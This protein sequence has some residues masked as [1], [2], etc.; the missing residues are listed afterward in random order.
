MT[1]GKVY[2]GGVFKCEM[3]EFDRKICEYW[4]LN[5]RLT[6]YYRFLT[7]KALEYAMGTN[8][9]FL[10]SEKHP[11]LTGV[12]KKQ[13]PVIYRK[14]KQGLIKRKQLENYFSGFN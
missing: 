2:K 10:V 4:T 14:Y 7:R 1:D 5:H 6:R 13:Y 8:I 3:K 12:I 11:D 9:T